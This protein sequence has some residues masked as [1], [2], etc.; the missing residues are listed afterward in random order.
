MSRVLEVSGLDG[1]YGSVQILNGISLHVDKGEFVTIIGPNGCGKS[2]FIK[3]IFGIATH[4]RGT[5]KH[6]GESIAAGAP[7]NWCSA[8]SPTCR[9]STTSFPG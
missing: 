5:V 1:G 4:Y 7:T 6:R 8:A 9:R 3:V 2:T